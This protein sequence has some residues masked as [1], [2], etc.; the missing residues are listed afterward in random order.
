MANKRELIGRYAKTREEEI[1]LG[2]SLDLAERADRG[3][4]VYSR[5][6]NPHE[7][8]IAEQM[9]R[10]GGYRCVQDGGYAMA[11]RC[12]LAFLPDYLEDTRQ[13]AGFPVRLLR[14]QVSG[15]HFGRELT[16]RDYLGALMSLQIER[17][18]IGDILTDEG[19]AQIFLLEQ[20]VP[21]VLQELQKVGNKSV[22]VAEVPLEALQSGQEEKQER[23]VFI[24]SLRLDAVVAEGFGLSRSKASEAIK[25]G[26]VYLQHVEC[27]RPAQEVQPGEVVALRGS[28]RLTVGEPDGMS[29]KGRTHI[30]FYLW[31]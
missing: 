24:A 8:S 31:K 26:L 23:S 11:E 13:D 25:S 1:L 12:V 16:H 27:L 29:K 30:K 2:R 19:G 14:V 7:R 18:L 4:A 15:R 17:E 21:V 6:L 28:G 5:F 3:Y 9:L 20:A 22:M 10:Q